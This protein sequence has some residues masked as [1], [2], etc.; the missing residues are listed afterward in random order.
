MWEITLP[1]PIG[2]TVYT[3]VC[4]EIGKWHVRKGVVKS[5][6]VRGE[7]DIEIVLTHDKS[8]KYGFSRPDETFSTEA[9][10]QARATELE[11]IWKGKNQ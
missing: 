11:E 1:F 10:A 6:H 5:Y 8:S 7:R 2:T 9:A 4:N 3:P